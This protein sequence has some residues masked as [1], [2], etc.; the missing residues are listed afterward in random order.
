MKKFKEFKEFGHDVYQKTLFVA[1]KINDFLKVELNLE[2]LKS[3]FIKDLAIDEKQVKATNFVKQ[4]LEK[5]DKDKFYRNRRI[6][7]KCPL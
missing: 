5:F 3:E 6:M 7:S 1:E 2:F 4:Q